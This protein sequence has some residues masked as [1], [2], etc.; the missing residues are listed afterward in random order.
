M[1]RIKNELLVTIIFAVGLMG[2]FM[3]LIFEMLRM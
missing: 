2:F 3:F 1:L